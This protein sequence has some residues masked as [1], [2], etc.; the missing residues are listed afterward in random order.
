MLSQQSAVA[1]IVDYTV[2]GSFYA[3]SLEVA[4]FDEGADDYIPVDAFLGGPS[5]ISFSSP[6]TLSFSVDE[7]TAGGTP[8]FNPVRLFDDA[9]SNVSLNINGINVL[10]STETETLQQ[11][12]GG[13]GYYSRWGWSLSD[14]IALPD[15]SVYRDSTGDFL[16]DLNANFINFALFNST[17][18]V[19]SGES[20]LNIITASL[21]DFTGTEF[22]VWWNM[23][24][25]DDDGEPFGDFDA[26]YAMYGSIDSI[27]SFSEVPLPAAAWLFMSAIGGLVV[28]KRKQLRA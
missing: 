8:I 20:H 6:F 17:D 26:S 21:E 27:S 23:D 10:A 19:F 1:A 9:V 14:N 16:T 4:E 25:G 28:S 13:N 11:F 5:P 18:S 3:D 22:S 15:V 7:A 12:P 24:F 2:T